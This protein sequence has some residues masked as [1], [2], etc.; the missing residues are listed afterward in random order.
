MTLVGLLIIGVPYAPLLAVV[1]GIFEMVP[2]LGPI[3][4]GLFMAL[5]TV[6]LAPDKVIWV[7]ALA[8]AVQLLENNVLVPRIAGSY[9]RIH[10]TLI[11][12]LLVIGA[13]YWG[14]WGM[15]LI[16]PLTATLIELFKYVRCVTNQ[17]NESCLNACPEK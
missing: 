3:I 16:V 1:N 11:L 15:V 2:T 5:L 14:I 9:M 17:A 13:Y 8:F 10:P 4:G 12:V 6:A 7:I